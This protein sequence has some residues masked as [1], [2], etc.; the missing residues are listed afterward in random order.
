MAVSITQDGPP[1]NFF[2]EW[3]YIFIATGEIKKDQLSKSDVTDADLLDL[4][5]KVLQFS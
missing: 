4:I 2:L 5:N 3:I 1:P